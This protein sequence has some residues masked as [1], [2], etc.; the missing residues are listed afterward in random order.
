VLEFLAWKVSDYRYSNV[1]VEVARIVLNM[2]AGV[3][4]M[5]DRVDGRLF[6]DLAKEVRQQIEL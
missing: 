2:Y 1:L 3:F 5:N 4:G 6:S